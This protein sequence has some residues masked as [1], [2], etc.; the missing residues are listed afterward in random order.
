MDS[1]LQHPA[2][3]SV[4]D[5]SKFLDRHYAA[6]AKAKYADDTAEF[7][8]HCHTLIHLCSEAMSKDMLLDAEFVYTDLKDLIQ[9][10]SVEF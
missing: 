8:K 5:H 7:L 3:K 10:C 1:I 4:L 9:N 6:T 2:F